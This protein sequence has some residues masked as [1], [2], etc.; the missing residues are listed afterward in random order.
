MKNILFYLSC[1]V[2]VLGIS[3][4]KDEDNPDRF[5]VEGGIVNFTGGSPS[6]IDLGTLENTMVSF[7]MENDGADASNVKLVKTYNGGTPVAIETI[8]SFPA[9]FEWDLDGLLDGFGITADDVQIGD[10]FAFSIDGDY[11]AGGANYRSVSSLEFPVSCESTLAGEYETMTTNLWCGNDPVTKTVTWTAGTAA[12]TYE[13]DDWGY[14]TYES[15]YG[16]SQ[17]DWGTLLLKD[18][19]NEITI[20]G[21]DAFTDTWSFSSLEVDGNNLTFTWTNTYG[22]GGTTT[23]VNPDGWPPLKLP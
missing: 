14:G 5:N 15:C 18:F 13:I 23:V 20:L 11:S 8:S 16:G 17:T 7:S 4:T 22:E 19:C 21:E 6:F 1:F 9:S 10:V 2:M 12:G 3:C